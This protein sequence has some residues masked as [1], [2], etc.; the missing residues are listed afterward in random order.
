MVIEKTA[1]AGQ[2]TKNQILFFTCIDALNISN[3]YHIFHDIGLFFKKKQKL[4]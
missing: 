2:K 3:I 1:I 4:F